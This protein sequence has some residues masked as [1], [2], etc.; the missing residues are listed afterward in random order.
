M[1]PS[2]GISPQRIEGAGIAFFVLAAL[3]TS[4]GVFIIIIGWGLD[5]AVARG[6]ESLL[7]G[8]VSAV[9]ALWLTLGKS[10]VAAVGLVIL[11]CMLVLSGLAAI[12][13]IRAG[14]GA[15]GVVAIIALFVAVKAV[16]ATFKLRSHLWYFVGGEETVG[17]LS[18]QELQE[19][20]TTLGNPGEVLIWHDGFSDWTNASNIPEL[21]KANGEATAYFQRATTLHRRAE[22]LGAWPN[23]KCDHRRSRRPIAWYFT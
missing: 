11:S 7:I 8:L 5:F 19:R 23:K 2:Q 15:G 14:G 21:A 1:A 6:L 18:L 9:L 17:P 12:F 22:A 13:V 4:L 10:R 3:L 20:L 16:E